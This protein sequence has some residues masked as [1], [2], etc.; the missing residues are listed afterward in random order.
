MREV[1]FRRFLDETNALR[2]RFELERGRV[3]KFV[4]QLESR[5]EG[6]D[7]WVPV[8]RYDTAHGYA[9]CDRLHPYEEATKTR[10]TTADYN[11]ALNFA[12]RDLK[13]NWATYRRS[14]EEWLKQQ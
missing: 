7:L 2:V 14:Y 1:E 9:H 10:M 4:V 8:V 5:F 3:L 11:E 13:G 6:E 12:L